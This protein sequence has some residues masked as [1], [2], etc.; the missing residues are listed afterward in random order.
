MR[1][2]GLRRAIWTPTVVAGLIGTVGLVVWL[3]VLAGPVSAGASATC[4]WNGSSSSLWSA[5]ANWTTT[6]GNSCTGTGGPPAGAAIIFPSGATRTSVTYDS[7]A[8]ASSFDSITFEAG[9]TVS[10]G[11]SAPPS[12]TLT[13]TAATAC[14]G[15]I[16]TIGL[17]DTYTSASVTFA[18]GVTLGSSEE[19]AAAGSAGLDLTGVISG[20]SS[21]ALTVGDASDTGI[22]KLSGANTYSGATTVSSAQLYLNS[23]GA[24][25]ST[26]GV[27]VEDNG[28]LSLN[29]A[30]VN[31]SEPLTLGSAGGA[32]TLQV[33]SSGTHTWSGPISLVASPTPDAFYTP[34]GPLT[35]AG[36]I[37]GGGS[38]MADGGPTLTLDAQNTYTGTTEVAS[39]VADGVA[40]ALPTGTALDVVATA[41]FDMAGFDQ[42]V[43]GLSG[44]GTVLDS[45]SSGTSTLTDT[46][47]TTTFSGVLENNA[48]TGGTV[49]LTV[50]GANLTLS[51]TDTYSGATTVSSGT[52]A[53][54]ISSG[55]GISTVSVAAAATLELSGGAAQPSNNLDLAGTLQSVG[56]GCGAVWGG[57]IT[58][59]ASTAAIENANSGC[60][61]LIGGA[62]SGAFDPTFANPG[63]Y[64][65]DLESLSGD[66]F[67]GASITSGSVAAD[68]KDA[69]GTGGTITVS[70]GARVVINTPTPAGPSVTLDIAGAG[71]F[72]SGALYGA[73]GGGTWS[74]P[75]VL[76]A[77]ATIGTNAAGD[78]L[79]AS[80][81]IYGSGP[82]TVDGPGTTRISAA[83]DY[84]RAT[85]V[86]SG[87]LVS[88]AANALP[89]GTT[90]DV[91]PGATFNLAGHAQQVASI[92]DD[93]GTITDSGAAADLTVG[94]LSSGDSVGE[95]L[96]GNLNLVA[97]GGNYNLAL[98]GANS[99]S[100][101]TRVSTGR[102]ELM[103]S[104]AL[105]S[106]SG[107]VVDSAADLMLAAPG[108]ASYGKPLT[109]GSGSA[110][111]AVLWGVTPGNTWSGPVTLAASSLGWFTADA[112]YTLTISGPVTGSGA[113]DTNGTG[114]VVLSNANDTYTGAT[115]A[116]GAPG[117]TLD[118]TGTLSASA[119]TV[120]PEATLE[121]TGTVAGIISGG[122]VHPGASPGV[123]TSSAGANLASGST[124]SLSVDITGATVGAG[125]SQLSAAGS[126]TL[127]G[128]TLAV[129]DSYPAAYGTVFKI[130]AAG[131]VSGTFANAA[132]NAVLTAG[133]RSLR[134]GYSATAVTLT[135]V[136]N[137]PPTVTAVSPT[138]GPTTGGTSVT[139][140]GT[141][142]ATAAGATTVDFGGTAATSV[143]C[144]STTSCS[145]TS[146]AGTA[147]TVDVTVTTAAGTSATSAADRFTY[148]AVTTGAP[149]VTGVTPGSG[150]TAGG[151]AVTVT[152]SNFVGGGTTVTFG[153]A[154]AGHVVV[155]SPTSLT[156]TTPA[157]AAGPVAVTATTVAGTSTQGYAQYL[158][159]AHPT[160]EAYTALRPYRILDTRPAHELAPGGQ[161]TLQVTGTGSGS[162]AVPA[163]AVATVLNV[164]VTEGSQAGV[165]TVYPEGLGSPPTSNLNWV[166]G[167]TVP[168]LVTV[169]LSPGGAVGIVNRSAGTVDVVADVEGYY[170]APVS[171]AGQY[172]ALTP[173]RILDTRSWIGGIAGPI[174]GGQT[175]T[176]QVTGRGGVPASG[177]A[178]VVLNVTVT[179]T[180]RSG[181][182]TAYPAG[183]P[184]PT[185]SNVN[186]VKGETVANRVMVP[187]GSTGRVALYNS[188][189]DTQIVVDVTGYLTT[190][191][192]AAGTDGLFVPVAPHRLLDTRVTGQTLGPGQVLTVPV[193]GQAAAPAS[194]ATAVVM[195][196]TVT[197]TT[198]AGYLTVYPAGVVRPTASDLNW[199]KG[200]T[201]PNMVVA[202]L[203]SGGA[204]DVY[205]SYGHT[206]VVIDVVGWFS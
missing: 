142:F 78:V 48:G 47:G 158:Y 10:E 87:T 21:D 175:I 36:V 94:T 5:G 2:G 68:H 23:S 168:N 81:V 99:Y 125:Y 34:N 149:T 189:G 143:S 119:V 183:A 51:G 113:L 17:C 92:T 50:N 195:N 170:A 77:A 9:Y 172:V 33:G 16:T 30:S 64:S 44:G 165:L 40:N 115:T 198:T 205:N 85:T 103:N 66:S 196:A 121:G 178:A 32:G 1:R 191:A 93:S 105:G 203:G 116:G 150:G 59:T 186:W 45:A 89:T 102:L 169:P 112:S 117:F 204:V 180:T 49:A 3:G 151:T 138:S 148:V 60:D 39:T 8:Q 13:P 108:G 96:T 120:D 123:L 69:L 124:G 131:S 111:G 161:L 146:P 72:A 28:T 190:S 133:G 202:T 206:D 176:P 104:T 54:T 126:A 197:D 71:P 26:S 82:L 75:V 53:T 128:A 25:G 86:S 76:T 140:T 147:G 65:I 127:T 24:L 141:D 154:A 19:F 152:G 194:G 41:T 188:Y 135:D 63:G 97:D 80:G 145:G 166:K 35:V 37:S 90:L 7:P 46:A 130:V 193:A 156:A 162:D 181:F 91:A 88:G 177:V 134:V 139:I 107:V 14:S 57:A 114:T 22:V 73:N 15:T 11:S 42:S 52:L 182:L 38:L 55:F 163:G 179:Q 185:A 199:V 122:T 184:R 129:A 98:S 109:L 106:T 159:L 31:Y 43:A 136:T 164:T 157:H 56:T 95:F 171:G 155:Q 20:A 83:G 70:S 27:T 160:G 84:T 118:V 174:A 201:V 100:G 144:S 101:S 192:V 62:I 6:S 4:T 58:L 61:L 167:Q 79:T 137:P 187:V 74:G 173:A 132:Q 110:P 12:I 18:P 153:G 29:T 200:Q 67:T